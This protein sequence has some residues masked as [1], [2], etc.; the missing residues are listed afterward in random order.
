MRC[1]AAAEKLGTVPLRAAARF[2]GVL[3]GGTVPLAP[4]ARAWVLKLATDEI[5]VRADPPT[6]PPIHPPTHPLSILPTRLLF[7]ACRSTARVDRSSFSP[8][9][10]RAQGLQYKGAKADHLLTALEAVA[11]ESPEAAVASLKVAVE[12]SGAA[13]LAKWRST[14]LE[15]VAATASAHPPFPCDNLSC[16]GQ[17]FEL[18]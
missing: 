11:K 16:G 7:P 14:A 15:V 13:L 4:E 1:G 5:K 8:S 10:P 17:A 6:H 3:A 9:V 2:L 18:R 12:K